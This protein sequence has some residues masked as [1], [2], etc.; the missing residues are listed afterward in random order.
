M[1][2]RLYKRALR[3]EYLTVGYNIVEGIVS[4]FAGWLAGSIA[5][6]GFGLDSGVESL[7]G[8]VLIWRLKKHGN[9]PEDEEENAEAAAVRFVGYSFLLLGFY[10][11]F[12]SVRKLYLH[13]HPEPTLLGIL[14]A[15]LSLITMPVLS[16]LKLKTARK[17]G[18]RS[19]EADS[20][21]TLVCALLSVA[22][23]FGLGLNYTLGLWWADPLSALVI[24][25][26]LLKEGLELLG[27]E[28]SES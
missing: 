24:V 5:L 6:I 10:V 17:I 3:L 14:I 18:S 26:F 11:L 4:I 20:K 9:V 25:A 22:L 28:L 16:Y 15:A 21:E 1:E 23:L 19:L 8:A 7:S 12:E 13:E 2:E 27:W